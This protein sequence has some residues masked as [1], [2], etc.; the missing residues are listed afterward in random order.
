MAEIKLNI[1]SDQIQKLLA[2]DRALAELLERVLNQV[3]EAELTEHLGAV[4]HERT[5]ERR[6]RR[7]S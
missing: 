1:E 4:P 3:L 6:S 7:W 5:P 2:S